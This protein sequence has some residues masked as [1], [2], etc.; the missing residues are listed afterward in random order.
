M[1]QVPCSADTLPEGVTFNH[2]VT[3]FNCISED[4]IF[5]L[6]GG[7]SANDGQMLDIILAEC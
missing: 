5:D 7:F 3:E 4:F 2:D 6:F 1:D